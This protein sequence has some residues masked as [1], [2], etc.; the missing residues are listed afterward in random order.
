DGAATSVAHGQLRYDT[1][2]VARPEPIRFGR[3]VVGLRAH[4]PGRDGL[5][6]SPV[7]HE[8]DA[9]GE[10]GGGVA[11]VARLAAGEPVARAHGRPGIRVRAGE[12]T[13]G[14]AVVARIGRVGVEV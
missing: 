7:E 8:V 2:V 11:E 1:G 9:V 14:V 5:D 13:I 3:P 10:L 6:V 4:D 12:E